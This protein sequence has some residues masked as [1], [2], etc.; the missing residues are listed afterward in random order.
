MAING[1]SQPLIPIYKGECYEIW[2]IKMK[3][4]FR[5]QDLWDL[6]EK[7]FDD[8]DVDEGR[9]K[10][11]RKKDLKTLFILQQA[12]HETIFSR[13]A[14]ASFS[15]EAWEI[16]Q[17]EIQG[18]SKVIAMK[19]QT[20][21]SEFEALLMKGNKTLQDFLSR[22][23]QLHHRCGIPSNRATSSKHHSGEHCSPPFDGRHASVF[24]RLL[25]SPLLSPGAGYTVGAVYS[26]L[27]PALLCLGK[28]SGAIEEPV[29]EFRLAAPYCSRAA[30]PECHW[31]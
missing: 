12:I 6:V 22:K 16:L 1:V 10:K 8:E 13:I 30:H 14:I 2:N 21:K 31:R 29:N 7:S 26:G 4:L 15:K 18:S 17:K 24:L 23:E 27:G 9:L 5:S 20:L 28:S 19:L 3:T 11:N 25:S